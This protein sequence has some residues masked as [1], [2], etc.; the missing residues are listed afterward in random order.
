MNLLTYCDQYQYLRL[1]INHSQ[2]ELAS[3]MHAN[4]GFV[5]VVVALYCFSPDKY[6]RRTKKQQN[7][8]KV[9]RC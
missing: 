9:I 7:L 2:V 4:T 1:T 6:I 3:K 8:A 5:V